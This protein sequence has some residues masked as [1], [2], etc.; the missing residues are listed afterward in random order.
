MVTDS[1]LPPQEAEVLRAENRALRLRL[2]RAGAAG[3]GGEASDPR[4][5]NNCVFPRFSAPYR[6][7]LVYRVLM[8]FLTGR[9]RRRRRTE[10]RGTRWVLSILSIAASGAHQMIWCRMQK[11]CINS[12]QGQ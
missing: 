11:V 2:Q 3:G 10:W 12:G 6:Q 9:R 1:P 4:V 7:F 8:I 5:C